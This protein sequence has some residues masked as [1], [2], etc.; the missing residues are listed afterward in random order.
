MYVRTVQFSP[1]T[2]LSQFRFLVLSNNHTHTHTQSIPCVVRPKHF[3]KNEQIKSHTR[4]SSVM[5]TRHH[6][7]GPRL[8]SRTQTTL[9]SGDSLVRPRTIR[10][11]C[12]F[13]PSRFY[14]R[15]SKRADFRS[16][17]VAFRRGGHAMTA[18]TKS[19]TENDFGRRL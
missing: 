12:L 17:H 15:P 6:S 2:P 7:A 5:L 3:G 8:M 11:S 18:T 9:G 10:V 4:H 1:V 19:V 14:R 13:S 16:N